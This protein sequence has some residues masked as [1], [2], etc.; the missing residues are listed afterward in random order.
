M[1]NC[2]SLTGYA[3][4]GNGADDIELLSGLS[5]SQRLTNDQLQSIQTKVVINA[6][7]VDGDVAAAGVY[8]N[9]C[10]GV[11][12]SACAVEIFDLRFVHV[13]APP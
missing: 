2:A 12:S 8:T 6:S 10:Y 11:L 5:Q 3:A 9:S 1:A 4:A 13:Q 7:V